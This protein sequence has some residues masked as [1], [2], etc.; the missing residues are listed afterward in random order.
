[1][2]IIKINSSSYD[3][4]YSSSRKSYG[5]VS[6]T[7]VDTLRLWKFEPTKY[8]PLFRASAFNLESCLI[9]AGLHPQIVRKAIK[10]LLKDE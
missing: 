7:E 2:R 10:E 6:F 5:K 3:V 8:S 1:M 9:Q 4:R